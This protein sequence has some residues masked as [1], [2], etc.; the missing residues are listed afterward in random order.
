M[1]ESHQYRIYLSRERKMQIIL[2]LLFRLPINEISD[3][4]YYTH[5]AEFQNKYF[6]KAIKTKTLPHSLSIL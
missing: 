6:K 2:P 4:Y 3:M 5:F 1:N